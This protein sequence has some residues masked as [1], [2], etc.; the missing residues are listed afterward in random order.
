MH[1]QAR[2][3]DYPAVQLRNQLIIS[4]HK[5]WMIDP[6][7]VYNRWLAQQHYRRH[8]DNG[9]PADGAA[10]VPSLD[11]RHLLHPQTRDEL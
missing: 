5:H 10:S 8:Q 3:D 7:D 11:R 4:F 9:H 2:P 1:L 6:V